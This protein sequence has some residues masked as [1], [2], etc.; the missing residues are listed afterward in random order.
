[1]PA[2]AATPACAAIGTTIV[3][4]IHL[5]RRRFVKQHWRVG[6]QGPRPTPEP[7]VWHGSTPLFR[8]RL[9]RMKNV[10]AGDSCTFHRWLISGVRIPD[11]GPA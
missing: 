11:F 5:I 3:P 6:V 4:S 10:T 8:A 2:A 7:T 1:M 9:R